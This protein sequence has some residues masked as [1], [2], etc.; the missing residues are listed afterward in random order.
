MKKSL[1]SGCLSSAV[2]VAVASGLSAAAFAEPATLVVDKTGAGGAYVSIQAAVDAANAGDTILVKPGVYDNG[3]KTYTYTDDASVTHTFTNRVTLTK[4]LHLKAE[5]R[6][7]ETVIIGAWDADTSTGIGPAAVRCVYVDSAGLGSVIEGFTIRDGNCHAQY[8]A[9]GKTNITDVLPN[10]GGGITASSSANTAFFAVGCVFDHC[11]GFRGGALR[12]GSAIRCRFVNMQG[13]GACVGRGTTFMNCLIDGNRTNGGLVM[14]STLVNCT[15]VGN[16]GTGVSFNIPVHLYNS[17]CVA[18]SGY[19]ASLDAAQSEATSTLTRSVVYDILSSDNP[20]RAFFKTVDQ[21][22]TNDDLVVFAPLFEDYR[23]L[24]G[25]AAEG[26]GDAAT[27]GE[28]LDVSGAAA[29]ID[30]YLDFNGAAIPTTG[31]INAGCIQATATA[32]GGCARFTGKVT[33]RGHAVKQD[34]V[35]LWAY[36]EKPIDIFKVTVA[37]QPYYW[38]APTMRMPEL[39]GG[40]YVGIPG[41][42]VVTTNEAVMPTATLTVD[43]N[44]PTKYQTIQAALDAITDSNPRVILVAEGVYDDVGYEDPAGSDKPR[45]ASCIRL[46]RPV[47]IVGAG[48]GKSTIRGRKAETA[49]G[50]GPGASRCVLFANRD[51]IQ[52]VQGFTLTGGRCVGTGTEDADANSGGL[53]L[54][55]LWERQYLLD[56]ELTDGYAYRGGAAKYVTLERCHVH[57]VKATGGAIVRPGR[58]RSS[59]VEASEGDS[60]GY[61]VDLQQ[62]PVAASTIVSSAPSFTPSPLNNSPHKSNYNSIYYSKATGSSPVF[63]LGE[64]TDGIVCYGKLSMS[65]REGTTPSYAKVDPLFVKA[66]ENDYRLTS[67]SP[68]ITG[69]VADVANYWEDP[70]LSDLNGNP[71][72]FVDGKPV[73]GA[74]Q[75]VVEALNITADEGAEVSRSGLVAVEPGASVTVTATSQMSSR[76][77]VGFE[78]DGEKILG[79][80]VWTYTAPADGSWTLGGHAVKAL[81]TSDWYVKPTGSDTANG[82]TPETAFATLTYAM[83]VAR[84]GDTVHALEG[85]YTAGSETGGG[86]DCRVVIKNGVSLVG[87]AGAEK[88]VIMGDEGVRPAA[89]AGSSGALRGVT[90]TGGKLAEDSDTDAKRGGGVWANNRTVTVC[91]CIISNNVCARGG[92]AYYCTL[93]NCRIIGN[94]GAQTSGAAYY[95]TLYGCYV[96]KN[97]CGSGQLLRFPYGLYNCTLGADNPKVATVIA[98]NM[99]AIENCAIL[100]GTSSDAIANARNCVVLESQKSRYGADNIPIADTAEAKLDADGR[101]A[102]DSPLVDAG[103]ALAAG[104]PASDFFGTQWY[105]NGTPDIGAYEYDWRGVYQ[106]D[107][108]GCATV[109]AADPQVVE[110][111]EG[112]VLVKAGA[113]T[114]RFTDETHKAKYRLPFQVT[115]T[116]TLTLKAGDKIV[117]T[118]TE[119]DGAQTL[120]YK[121]KVYGND[122]AFSYAPGEN[123]AGGALLDA[124]SGGVPGILVIVR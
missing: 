32:A 114:I 34:G 121:N 58:L 113:I 22:V 104:M 107:L 75:T 68:A 59:L 43:K 11:S 80:T 123:D 7:D 54:G 8:K 41:K 27:I 124:Q 30:L 35:S 62:V 106:T 2:V 90:L 70:C 44:D 57:G 56:C 89:F 102:K 103:G 76:Q 55:G 67:C 93:V 116:G 99:G 19:G 119:A 85:V 52:I 78:V 66:T 10:R 73:P 36:S 95:S 118:Y 79:E 63:V 37:G 92:A 122:L 13:S 101:P 64:Y 100:C 9:D 53:A 115:G 1:V 33:A 47:R 86:V 109:E 3:F 20:R 112:K 51:V 72:L 105:Y 42:G 38:N 49:D 98:D 40:V 74:V 77:V 65:A 83:S 45:G 94:K 4:K 84:A 29:P 50:R 16:G 111:D 87:D 12:Y 120:T 69:G 71:R 88:T 96:D 26:L 39:D 31:M 117:G 46:V 97:T 14:D 18:N 6:A 23:V 25:S 82:W 24:A 61:M 91:D 17:I 5:G 21:A 110:T 81:L 15:V 28:N 108:G 48:R 60:G